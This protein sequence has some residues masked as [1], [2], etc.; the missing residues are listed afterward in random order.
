MTLQPADYKLPHDD[1]REHQLESIHWCEDMDGVGI[2]EAPTGSGKTSFCAAVSQSHSV[3]ALVRTKALQAENYG[4]M[5]G[6]EV[7][8]GRANYNC[9]HPDNAGASCA[10]CLHLEE[11]MHRCA[12]SERCTYLSRK[13]CVK[14]SPFASLNYPYYLTAQWP[15]KNPP[16]VLFLDEAHNVPEIITQWSGATVTERDRIEWSLPDFPTITGKRQNGIFFVTSGPPPADEAID[17]LAKARDTMAVHYRRLK[18]EA[19]TNA[20]KRDTLQKCE[21]LGHKLRNAKDALERCAD[22]W[23]IRAGRTALKFGQEQRPGF[24]AKPLTA[25]YHFPSYFLDGHSTIAMSATIGDP[26]TFCEELGVTDYRFRAVPSRFPPE[27]RQ[28]HVLDVPSMGRKATQADFEHQADAIAKAILSCPASWSGF[29]HVTRKREAKLLADR[30][31][32][33]GLQDRV[34]VP[35]GW[36]GAYAPTDKQLSAWNTRRERVPGSLCVGWSFFEGIDGLEERICIAAKVPWG[37]LGD[38]Y[39]R[40]RLHY[41]G[42]MYQQRA[43]WQLAQGLG[44]TRRGREQDYDLGERR[45][46]VCIAD[47]SWSRVKSKLPVAVSEAIVT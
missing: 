32:H 29:I 18:K 12:Y 47:G 46:L 5:Y 2:V 30:L 17:W 34:W 11:G 13:E 3:I 33:R 27:A 1:W 14:A 21:H 26:K 45:G 19:Q 37:Y 25:K 28:V 6:A 36:D 22:D 40:E 35:P 7:L 38:E 4:A 15:R 39:E 16:Q 8:Y 20:K 44:R 23:Y 10:D 42:S 41:S 31:A 43:A 24:V 9:V